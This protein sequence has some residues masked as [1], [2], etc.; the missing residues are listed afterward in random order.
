MKKEFSDAKVDWQMIEYSG[1][2]HSFTQP[3]VGNDNARGAAYNE[4]ADKRSWQHMRAFFDEV[5]G[6]A[7]GK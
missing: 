2:V 7:K 3:M 1:A 6:K 5:I 4:K